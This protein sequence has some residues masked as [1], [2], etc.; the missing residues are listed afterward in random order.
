LH[1]HD[2]IP[3]A[4]S[5][6]ASW[7]GSR[8]E[9]VE[10]SESVMSAAEERFSLLLWRAALAG[11]L[12]GAVGTLYFFTGLAGYVTSPFLN[13]L[14]A[15]SVGGAAVFFFREFLRTFGESQWPGRCLWLAILFIIF[16]EALLSMVP[17]TA[18]DELTHHLA[19]PRLYARAGRII[20][21]PMAPYSYYPMLLDMLYTPWVVW[22]LDWVPKLIHALF[23]YLT[24]L[25]LYAYLARRMNAAYGL[26]GFFFFLSIPCVLRLSHWAYVDLGLTYYTTAAL[27]CLLRWHEQKDER[28]WLALSGVSAGFAVATKPNGLVALLLIGLLFVW[29]LAREPKRRAGKIISDLVLIG[30][31]SALPFLPWLAKNWY[32]TG[33]PFFPL[34]G[35]LFAAKGP[36]ASSPAQYVT[37]GVLAKRKLFYDES[38]WQIAALPLRLFFFGQDDNP[39]YFDGVLSPLLI[40]LLPWAFK[41]K[42]LEEKRLLFAFACLYLAYSLFL[43]DLRA[44]YVL[45]IVP[46]LVALCCYGVF[47]TYLRIKQPAYL[48]AVLLFFAGYHGF[49]LYRYFTEIA[50]IAFLLGNE[51]RAAYLTRAL[52]EY[53]TF[54]FINRELPPSAKIYLLFIGRRGY[55]CERAYIHDGGELPALLLGAIQSAQDP[56]QIANWLK[57]HGISHLMV[58]TDLLARYLVD[59][60]S[61]AKITLWNEFAAGRLSLNFQ[62]RGYALYQ[63]HG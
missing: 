15:A 24:A 58:R 62:K 31:A 36:A 22:G 26:I 39:Q 45:L 38:W 59:N 55:Y 14:V 28:S 11:T 17:P 33:N 16:V 60:L 50:P 27:V 37:L 35:G 46:P 52:P 4:I 40:L 61:P 48:I 34:L 57:R 12:L 20:E 8:D 63:L 53:P 23:G 5:S 25:L 18:R 42:W 49:Y 9:K 10:P 21:V 41:G 19:I 54:E 43:V 32:Q 47:N 13:L 2:G 44:R 1:G 51:S 6:I 30:V 3:P 56:A 29:E 7:H